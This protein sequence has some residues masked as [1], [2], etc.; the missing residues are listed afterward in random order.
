MST[1]RKPSGRTVCLP[2]IIVGLWMLSVAS[3]QSQAITNLRQLTE[4]LNVQS[5]IFRS[6][7]LEGVVCAASQP[8]IG[9]LILK[10]DSGVELLEMGNLGQEVHP[11]ERIRIQGFYCLLRKR[12]LGIEISIAPTVDNDGIHVRR[13]W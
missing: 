3:V 5:R 10:D 12:S 9:V 1:N 13:T 7:Q 11:G 8:A 6:V 4:T 2:L